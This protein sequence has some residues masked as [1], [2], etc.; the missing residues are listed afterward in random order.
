MRQV[1][2]LKF[3]LSFALLF[4]PWIGFSAGKCSLD[5]IRLDPTDPVKSSADCGN[6]PPSVS[7]KT[8]DTRLGKKGVLNIEFDDGFS[9]RRNRENVHSV[10]LCDL[11][12]PIVYQTDCTFAPFSTLLYGSASIHRT[13]YGD[14]ELG[15]GNELE[16]EKPLKLYSTPRIQAGTTEFKLGA[17]EESSDKFWVPCGGKVFLHYSIKLELYSHPGEDSGNYESYLGV[18]N[19][20]QK[21]RNDSF[22]EMRECFE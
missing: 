7:F 17:K 19:T 22:W 9:V 15:F 14:V 12:I 3:C 20:S 1:F 11:V 16:P 10:K 4:L 21:L 13:H 8:K 5:S 6:H 18:G 2:C